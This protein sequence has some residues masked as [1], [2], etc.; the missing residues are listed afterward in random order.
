MIDGEGCINYYKSKAPSMRIGY[1]FVARVFITNSH[2]ET[3]F[4]IQQMLGFGKIRQRTKQGGN[5][6]IAYNLEF[7]PRKSK[8]LLDEVYCYLITKKQQAKLMIEYCNTL[9]WGRGAGNLLTGK[10][11]AYRQDLF[12]EMKSLNRR[13]IGLEI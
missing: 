9:K 3:L 13:G 4:S 10:E 8:V 12:Y 5:R 1:T 11:I 7:S 2:F 6:K